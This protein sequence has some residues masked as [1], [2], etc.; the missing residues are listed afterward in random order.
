M[1]LSSAV[2]LLENFINKTELR[3]LGALETLQLNS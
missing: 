3:Q 1:S 2:K